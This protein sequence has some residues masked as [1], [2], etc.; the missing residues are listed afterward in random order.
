MDETN[1]LSEA[2]ARHI[3]QLKQDRVDQ[4]LAA[5]GYVKLDAPHTANTNLSSA[6][7]S[8]TSTSPSGMAAPPVWKVLR[9]LTVE[10][11]GTGKVV[12]WRSRGRYTYAAIFADHH[13]FITGRGEWYDTNK[14]T[15][16][17]LLQVL[18]RDEVTDVEL[19]N[20][21]NHLD[22]LPPF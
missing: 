4:D 10:N 15:P 18:Q 21:W 1:P 5:A 19:S 11:G 2:A 6:R 9:D 20:T 12:R 13:W 7:F 14:L 22:N 8:S 3:K 16:Q 17:Q